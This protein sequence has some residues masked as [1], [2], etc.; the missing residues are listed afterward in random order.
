MASQDYIVQKNRSYV[1]KS[2]DVVELRDAAKLEEKKEKRHTILI[3]AAVLSALVISGFII[4][5]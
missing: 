2:V 1:T 3:T 4:S 5:L